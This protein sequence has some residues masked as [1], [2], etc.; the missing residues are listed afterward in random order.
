MARA[1]EDNAPGY[2]IPNRV[3]ELLDPFTLPG[4]A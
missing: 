3:R 1:T 2:L 4:S